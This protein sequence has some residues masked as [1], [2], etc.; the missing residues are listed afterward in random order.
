MT[1]K[2]IPASVEKVL[3]RIDSTVFDLEVFRT[4]GVFVLRGALPPQVVLEWQKTWQHFYDAKLRD[5]RPVNQA[6]PVAMTEELPD[7]L[8]QMYMEPTMVRVMQQIHGEHIALFDH[9]FVIKDQ[10][11]RGKVFLHQDSCYQLGT[12]NKCTFF[13]P[14]SIANHDNGAMR[15]YV[16]SHKLGF[17]GDAGEINPDAF[18]VQWPVICPDLQP[19]DF[20]VMHSSLWH[21]SVENMSGIN[22]ILAATTFQPA[23]D[24]T[25]KALIAGEWQTDVFYSPENCIRYFTNSRSLRNIRY[26]KERAE[27]EK[28]GP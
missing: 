5:G 18:D 13:T 28:S 10:F 2:K 7:L 12:L 15:F 3:G 23:D 19:G 22:R 4:A 8:A 6:N 27:R 20:V 26:E 21:D 24:P 25:G 9:R 1:E 16:G 17:L 11:S 14:L